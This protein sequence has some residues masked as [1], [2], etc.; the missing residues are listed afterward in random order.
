MQ[1][2]LNSIP[3]YANL[4]TI[5]IVPGTT[6]GWVSDGGVSDDGDQITTIPDSTQQSDGGVL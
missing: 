5:L 2:E 1:V 3:L 6:E 4:E